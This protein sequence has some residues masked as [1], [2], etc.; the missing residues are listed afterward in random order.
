MVWIKPPFSSEGQKGMKLE[1]RK[2]I[3]RLRN[4]GNQKSKHQELAK[5]EHR[6]SKETEERHALKDFLRISIPE[7]GI[8][9]IGISNERRVLKIFFRRRDS[10]NRNIRISGVRE[11]RPTYRAWMTD[12]RGLTS[13]EYLVNGRGFPIQ[14][15]RLNLIVHQMG[16]KSRTAR[17]HPSRPK[18]V[19][20]EKLGIERVDE[21]SLLFLESRCPKA[22]SLR[23]VVS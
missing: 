4:F 9:G 19:A 22:N 18:W 20:L 21:H 13:Y 23:A 11:H 3:W 6:E 5:S 7:I 16:R 17:R 14:W 15:R 12:A 2:Q 10:H 1:I 8:S